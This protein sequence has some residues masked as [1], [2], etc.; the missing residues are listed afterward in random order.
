MGDHFWP[1]VYPGI[2]VG[3]LYGLSVGGWRNA[4]LGA[5]GALIATFV[6]FTLPGSFFADDELVSMLALFAV[7]LAGAWATVRLSRFAAS[8]PA[9]PSSG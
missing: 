7:A 1:A 6:G 9:R 3:V 5:V 2:A 4:L 8:R